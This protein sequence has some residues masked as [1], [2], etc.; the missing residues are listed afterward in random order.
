MSF[1]SRQDRTDRR[2]LTR[3]YTTGAFGGTYLSSL[4]SASGAGRRKTSTA[5]TRAGRPCSAERA[6]DGPFDNTIGDEKEFVPNCRT[7]PEDLAS[8][9]LAGTVA[10]PGPILSGRGT[11]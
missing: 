9:G 8:F 6:E 5:R 1:R 11:A 7:L 10:S 2:C 3:L 4:D